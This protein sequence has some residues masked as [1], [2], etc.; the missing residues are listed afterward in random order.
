MKKLFALLL[1]GIATVTTMNAQQ[2]LG[3]RLGGG[4]ASGAEVSYQ[5]DLGTANRLEADLGS[6]GSSLSLTG[7]SMGMGFE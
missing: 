1:V 2:A 7:I 3:L 6:W 5:K 4:T